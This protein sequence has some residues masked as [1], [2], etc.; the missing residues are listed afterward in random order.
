MASGYGCF[1]RD[2]IGI[3][4]LDSNPRARDFAGFCAHL[5]GQ[6]IGSVS[7]DHNAFGGAIATIQDLRPT[8]PERQPCAVGRRS[9][10]PGKAPHFSAAA[11]STIDRGA[12]RVCN[13]RFAVAQIA[14]DGDR[15]PHIA[16]NPVNVG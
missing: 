9:A 6:M 8:T 2:T 5:R 7:P 11:R 16:G 1:A 14:Q 12:C 4:I 15:V 3:R 13:A 10:Y